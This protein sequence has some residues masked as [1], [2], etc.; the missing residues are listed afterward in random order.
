ML[1]RLLFVVLTL[2]LTGCGG[3]GSQNT[4]S[5]SPQNNGDADNTVK[6]FSTFEE[7]NAANGGLTAELSV[8]TLEAIVEIAT[9]AKQ[10]LQLASVGD[11]PTCQSGS[12]VDFKAPE[13]IRNGTK[14]DFRFDNCF[15]YIVSDELSGT[16]QMEVLETNQL[17][18]YAFMITLDELQI[19][20]D[21]DGQS[22]PISFLGA[23]KVD[24]RRSFGEEYLS[25][26]LPNANS[27]FKF[28]FSI[29]YA[30]E[31]I[32]KLNLT[33]IHKYAEMRYYID[34]ELS[35][36]S[37]LV[38]NSYLA[39][40]ITPFSGPL[41]APA[42]S[43]ELL[44]QGAPS[45]LKIEGL[46]EEYLIQVDLMGDGTFEA[47][48]SG[49]VNW[50]E[51]VEGALFYDR[52]TAVYLDPEPSVFSVTPGFQLLEFVGYEA[53]SSYEY[54]ILPNS[55]L[56]LLFSKPIDWNSS[57]LP[58][59]RD[60]GT[61]DK[62]KPDYSADGAILTINTSLDEL[63]LYWLEMD[64]VSFDSDSLKVSKKLSTIK[65]ALAIVNASAIALEGE[66]IELDGGSLSSSLLGNISSF[67]WHQLQGPP[68]SFN[69]SD[70]TISL[71][72]PNIETNFEEVSFLL[73]IVDE[74]NHLSET[75][76]RFLILNKRLNRHAIYI[77]FADDKE[78]R[79][80]LVK[81]DEAFVEETEDSFKFNFMPRAGEDVTTYLSTKLLEGDYSSIEEIFEYAKLDV[82]WST[83]I[84]VD[85]NER[86]QLGPISEKFSYV[87]V[88]NDLQRN[89]SGNV[90][91]A[92]V[93]SSKYCENYNQVR[94]EF[95]L[96]IKPSLFTVFSP[97]FVVRG[98]ASPLRI[99]SESP[100]N[101]SLTVDGD[102]VFNDEGNGLFA[103]EALAG[104]EGSIASVTISSDNIEE[105]LELEVIDELSNSEF[106]YFE[107]SISRFHHTNHLPT[108]FLNFHFFNNA[109]R[110][111][112][113]SNALYELEIHI[114][115]DNHST[116]VQVG[117]PESGIVL[118]ERYSASRDWLTSNAHMA[119]AYGGTMCD[120]E[121]W[122]E[123][124]EYQLD[125]D[126]NIQSLA[127]DFF[128]ECVGDGAFNRGAIRFNS[129]EAVNF[130]KFN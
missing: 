87:L 73:K 7:F 23:I 24:F 82:N 4:P 40:F 95:G 118:G 2:L 67:D 19:L 64:L 115:D 75:E 80:V 102:I 36:E 48:P 127:L 58:M 15:D 21:S 13:T 123:V 126:N 52:R 46:G 44:I 50:N 33:K 74:A 60:N 28:L 38:E 92:N 12:V 120:K 27:E 124:L 106:L 90:V 70:S 57:S 37:E 98:Q 71:A 93:Q 25:L 69:K 9:M 130:S 119:T 110:F 72:L 103:I 8:I 88:S 97:G 76:F 78:K 55:E 32:K 61:G 107:K 77:P 117:F 83:G 14:I 65:P 49:S 5:N 47:I 53:Q 59:F 34:G 3:G 113:T 104:S 109:E 16:Y 17:D 68:L 112:M 22:A 111:E 20:A 99:T 128:Q 26:A 30:T 114:S 42:D 11:A 35:V 81:D 41:N 125:S 129:N 51:I 63:R 62:T 10:H 45:D 54:S 101:I 66:T 96:H 94:T 39:T 86:S 79:V 116:L 1:L 31:T 89:D 108:A 100:Q 105:S 6:P 29:P 121:G 18:S 43:G 84:N 91:S 122:Y 85:C 56:K